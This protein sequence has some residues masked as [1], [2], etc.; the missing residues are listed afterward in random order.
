LFTDVEGSTRR[1]QDEPESMRS[2]LVEHDV[3]LREAVQA[4]GGFLFKHT[5]DGIA[6]AFGS[7]SDA[8]R[9]SVDAQ[10]RLRVVLPVR[11]GLH[12]GEA[13][14][15]GD[16]YFGT[17]LNRCARLMGVA[18]GGQIVCGDVT[19]GL[20]RDRAEL[21]DLGEHRL[22]DLSRAER[23]WQVG[24]GE[25]PALRSLESYPSNLPVQSTPLVGRQALL[26]EL[27]AVVG[28]EPVVT[29]TGVGGVG[30]TRLA[31]AVGADLLPR[32]ADG[33]WLVELAPLAHDEMVVPTI[34]EALGVAAQ[35]GEPLATTVASRLKD[36]HLL[37]IFDNCEHVIGP[38]AR[39]AERLAGAAPGVRIV[40][41]SR[42]PLGIAV[43]R[44]RAVPPLAETTEAVELFVER[45]EHAGAAILESHRPA[46]KDICVRLDGIPLAIE[47]AAAR[48]R[49]MTPTEI[50][51]RLDQRFRLLTGGGR[52]AIERHRTLHA[53]VSW[54]Y[55]LL[56]DTERV[57]FQRLSTLSGSFDLA[58]AEA[59]AGGGVVDEFEVLDPL[60]HLV[61]KSMVEAVAGPDTARYRLLET[62]RQFAADRLAEQPDAAEVQNRHAAF[63]VN[64][65]VASGRATGGTDPTAGLDAIDADIDNYRSAFA[66]LLSTGRINDTARG[67]QA[68]ATYWQI[69]RTREGLAWQRQLLTHPDLDTRRRLRSLAAAARAEVQVGD[70]HAAE[71]TATEA[72]DL[73]DVEGV[74]APY[75]AYEALMVVAL[76]CH[77]PQARRRWWERAHQVTAASGPP[78]LQLLVDAQFGGVPGAWP[79]DE[80]IAHYERLEP[81]IR[82]HGDPILTLVFAIGFSMALQQAGQTTR[83]GA[84]ARGAI[85]AARRAGPVG[86]TATLTN[87]A[88]IDV[89]DRD[90]QAATTALAES[91]R[92]ARDE[93]L[94]SI[95]IDNAFVAAALAA[96][97][98]D[99]ETAAVLLAAAS[100]HADRLGAGPPGIQHVCR[101]QAQSAVDAHPGDLTAARHHGT[102][103][104][105]D[106]LI[107]FAL[108]SRA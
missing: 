95:A 76:R 92:L 48:A 82:H 70:M 61:D 86:Y 101:L 8:V 25:F 108:D 17:T 75:A 102:S 89:L 84:I 56:D 93:G 38:V 11:M 24:A 53:T 74:D 100:R 9:A 79:S 12:T 22:R 62:L 37:A 18:H 105:L 90:L 43:E 51:E 107:T 104:T 27:A 3:I 65:A 71:R 77:D 64:R 87:V 32:F 10:D 50:A 6:A 85:E 46:I 81:E 55:E 23:V 66:H 45:A 20:V 1:W 2:L 106:D 91:L 34:A 58:A 26:A 80:V 21:R 68:L 99:L 78:Y 88:A 42:E 35:T 15:R 33:V 47:L 5:G 63:W 28:D 30:K 4:H 60:G 72:I 29:L 57:V 103:M 44:V 94:T 97:R 54:S 39:L 83:A 41:T 36:K 59:I 19:A 40:A 98:E 52:T 49:M 31:L 14:L 96:A 69:R 67:V 16:D 13:E 7:A 73:A